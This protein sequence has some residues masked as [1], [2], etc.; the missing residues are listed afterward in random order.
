MH[1][2]CNG[3]EYDPESKFCHGGIV[4]SKC[5]GK[6]FEPG[7]FCIANV[8]YATCGTNPPYNIETHF[9]VGNIV[10]ALNPSSS[11]SSN[12]CGGKDY[13][14]LLFVCSGNNLYAQCG[15]EFYNT[16]AHFCR[17][18]KTHP[19]CSGKEYDPE[20]KFCHGGT[21]EDKCGGKE[22]E[23]SQFCIGNAIYATC[24]TNPPYNIE[25]HFCAG[26]AVRQKCGGYE[27]NVAENGCC[28]G[29]EYPLE[30]HFCYGGFAEPKCGGKEYN[31]AT[32]Q[33][34]DATVYNVTTQACLGD[35]V[36]NKCGGEPYNTA[37]Q[38][39]LNGQR[40]S[41]CGGQEYNPATQF[42]NAGSVKN[43]CGGKEYGLNQ[44]CIENVVYST[45]GVEPYSIASQF[46]GG[47]GVIYPLC[48]GNDYNPA[49]HF[50]HAG[51]VT[52]KC[53][54][55]TYGDDEF[56]EG[57]VIK[58]LCG[59]SPYNSGT[60]FCHNNTI[61]AKCGG[62]VYDPDIYT[63]NGIVLSYT[64]EDTRDQ[65]IYKAVL[66][67]EQ[68]WMAENLNFNAVGS[69]CYNDDPANCNTYGRLYNWAMAM[70][71]ADM[72]NNDANRYPEYENNKGICPDNWHVPSRSEWL[73]LAAAVGGSGTDG[74]TNAGVRLKAPLFG[75]T[76]DFGFAALLGGYWQQYATPTYSGL[77]STGNWWSSTQNSGAGINLFQLN[78]NSNNMSLQSHSC[79]YGGNN[80]M[81]IS[82]KRHY[83]S[84]RCVRN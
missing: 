17:G 56:C 9:C 28:G 35:N 70:G 75:G 83:H 36:Y 82:C 63:C 57:G 1:L 27:Y 84:L 71:V 2:L 7:Q 81:Y 67:G 20:S 11:S 62:R 25:T 4:E 44:F 73:E 64:F 77:E 3:K 15:G 68:V 66:I 45:C 54:G 80:Y 26:N 12:L 31:P 49:T 79:G 61:T 19:L 22:F 47:D 48:G 29:K 33:C 52:E 53:G 8:I 5:N 16:A 46:C 18:N 50:C 10:A 58:A 38:F 42:C 40:Y 43:K 59:V 14:P 60:H 39:C 55:M 6:E 72:F 41:L 23:P 37:T 13:D 69:V 32:H 65:K 30:T 78:Y 74:L 76:N 34:C 51:L 24:G 21:I